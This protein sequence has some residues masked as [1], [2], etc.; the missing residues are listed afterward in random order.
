[1]A[2][3]FRCRVGEM[4]EDHF[5]RLLDIYGVEDY[6]REYRFAPPRRYR[7]DFAWPAERVAVE[8]D[9]GTWKPGGGRHGR[10]VDREK[11]NLAAVSGWRVL[12]FST[13]MLGR[14]P[15]GCVEML[16]GALAA[17]PAST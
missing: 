11:L 7:F 4:A 13:D 12:R 1:M 3:L 14:D 5:A 16:K 8:I 15:A 2:V 6:E 9:G 10:D 17:A